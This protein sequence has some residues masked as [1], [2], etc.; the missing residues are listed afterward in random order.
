MDQREPS[1]ASSAN[2]SSVL[3]YELIVTSPVDRAEGGSVQ[4]RGADFVKFEHY[5][6]QT[7]RKAALNANQRM[8]PKPV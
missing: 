7:L 4:S 3:S 2:E 6:G 8:I 5:L 1:L